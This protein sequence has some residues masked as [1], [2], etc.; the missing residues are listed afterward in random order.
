MISV[1]RRSTR[2]A[3]TNMLSRLMGLDRS[4]RSIQSDSRIYWQFVIVEHVQNHTQIPDN[5]VMMK[6]GEVTGIQVFQ[7]RLGG[8]WRL[9]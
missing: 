7:D 9:R 5:W 4:A 6:G 2:A 8:V 1:L 3:G